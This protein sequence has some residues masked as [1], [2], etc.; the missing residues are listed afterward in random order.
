MDCFFLRFF[1]VVFLNRCPFFV[2]FVFFQAKG[3]RGNNRN[4][5]VVE[6]FGLHEFALLKPD[7]LKPLS[8]LDDCPNKTVR[9]FFL[10]FFNY[11]Y[12]LFRA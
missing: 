4:G 3:T 7:A 5:A 2:L 1:F 12:F 6:L 11:F 9:L 10:L 8:T